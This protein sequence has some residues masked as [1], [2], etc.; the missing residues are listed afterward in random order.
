MKNLEYETLKEEKFELKG[1][2]KTLMLHE[3]RMKFRIRAKMVKYVKFNFSSDPVYSS[4]L[5]HCT[6]CDM[7]DSQSHITKCES[8]KYLREDKDLNSD[9]DLV[10][11]FSDVI[12]LREKIGNVV[13]N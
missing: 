5:W 12:S 3:G 4:Q 1:Y 2:I 9:K 11:Y 8:Y 7:M 13:L 10:K 6:H